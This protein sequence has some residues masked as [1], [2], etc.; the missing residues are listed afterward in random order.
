MKDFIYNEMMVHVA[1]CTNKN[2]ENILI[3]SDNADALVAEVQKHDNIPFDV[4]GADLSKLRE[5]TDGSY[6]VVISELD[7]DAAILAHHNRVLKED[8]LLVTTH[9]SLDNTDENKAIMEILGRYTKVIM[10]F[11]I[12]NGETALL[13][14]KEYHPTADIILHRA[15]MLDN[16]DYYNCDVHPAA[17]AM[18]NNVRKEY[19]GIIKN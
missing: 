11:N 3:V 10:P 7:S 19:L 15:D 6:D 13:A 12:G 4:I 2:P 1:L 5:L 16:L 18:G 8:G 17:F 14:S 9:P